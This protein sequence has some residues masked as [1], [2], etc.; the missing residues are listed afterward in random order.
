MKLSSRYLL[1][2]AFASIFLLFST[3]NF[4]FAQDDSTQIVL[5]F[6]IEDPLNRNGTKEGNPNLLLETPPNVES[7]VEYNPATG[8]YVF[9]NN[10]C[11][12]DNIPASEMTL[13]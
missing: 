4:S 7:N 1:L 12:V 8:K 13:D 5:P 6:P 10:L 9:K 11:K 3:V 2:I